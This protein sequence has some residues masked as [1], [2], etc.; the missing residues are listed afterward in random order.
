MVNLKAKMKN[1]L[2]TVFQPIGKRG[3]LFGLQLRVTVD[4]SIEWVRQHAD[5]IAARGV[6]QDTVARGLGRPVALWVEVA[7]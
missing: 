4:K 2:L 3:D 1:Y 6:Q 5:E 7:A